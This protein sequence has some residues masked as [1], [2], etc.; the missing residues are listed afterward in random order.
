MEFSGGSPLLRLK[1][2]PLQTCQM[3]GCQRGAVQVRGRKFGKT[4]WQLCYKAPFLAYIIIWLV[5]WY[6]PKKT[7]LCHLIGWSSAGPKSQSCGNE[8]SSG[9]WVPMRCWGVK[10]ALFRRSDFSMDIL[11]WRKFSSLGIIRGAMLALG[12]PLLHLSRP[13]VGLCFFLDSS[14]IPSNPKRLGWATYSWCFCQPGIA[15]ALCKQMRWNPADAQLTLPSFGSCGKLL[16]GSW[17]H[18]RFKDT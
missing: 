15:S 18:D 6:D 2:R 1:T 10:S 3:V 9:R 17:H 14:A 13:Y 5:W 8:K 12:L 16:G 11:D 7:P 4:P